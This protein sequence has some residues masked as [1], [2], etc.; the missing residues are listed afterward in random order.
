MLDIL[1][2]KDIL[3]CVDVTVRFETTEKDWHELNESGTFT[4]LEK[5]LIELENKKEKDGLV[6][7][8]EERAGSLEEKVADLVREIQRQ[9]KETARE[10][11]E[12]AK[13]LCSTEEKAMIGIYSDPEFVIFS[14]DYMMIKGNGKL[15]MWRVGHISQGVCVL[16]EGD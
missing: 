3:G 6:R 11:Y 8:S 7:I 4:Q 9:Q 15:I 16:E 14:P 10:I 2:R 12:L 5:H 1:V 13:H